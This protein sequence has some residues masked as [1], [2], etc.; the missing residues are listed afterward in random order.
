MRGWRG[1]RGAGG[2]G[3]EGERRK[4]G[5]REGGRDG[6]F[7]FRNIPEYSSLMLGGEG[8]GDCRGKN[9][10]SF[11]CVRWMLNVQCVGG[12]VKQ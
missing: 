12:D 3:G 2:G 6:V 1:N 11:M 9:V 5:W 4:E 7:P 8:G 10:R